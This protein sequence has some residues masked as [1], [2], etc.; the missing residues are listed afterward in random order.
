MTDL[1]ARWELDAR[2]QLSNRGVPA[3]VADP[4]IEDARRHCEGTGEDPYVAFGA[5][6]EFAETTAAEVPEEQRELVD[7]QGKTTR[8]HL[9]DGI[10]LIGAMLALYSLGVS[11]IFG[12]WSVRVTAAG[13]TGVT[14][15][16]LAMAALFTVPPAMRAA[17]RPQLSAIGFIGGAA[18]ILGAA[19]AFKT[20]PQTTLVQA[21][22]LACV[23][24]GVL[25]SW[26]GLRLAQK[27]EAPAARPIEDPE[28]WYARLRGVLIG[29]HDLSP[30]RAA[31]LVAQARDH[32]A[33]AGATPA[34]EFGDP[35]RYA[36]RLAEPEPV[37]EVAWWRTPTVRIT[38]AALTVL[39][40]IRWFFGWI[41]HGY[42]WVAF[43]IGIPATLSF[44]WEMIRII[45]TRHRAG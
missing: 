35:D 9:T 32:A 29:R 3:P 37:H 7:R 15:T 20:L 28:Q 41:D 40:S 33:L 17:G 19:T 1:F 38:L 39:A 10:F 2:I 22:A 11:L 24:L 12:S 4:H 23:A 14:L 42:A 6:A 13:L 26:L 36:A 5:P 27:T 18:L 8:D 43:L 45:R 21:P 16:L 25:L 31:E 34:A 44:L 30:E